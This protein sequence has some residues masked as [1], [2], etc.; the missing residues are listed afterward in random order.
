[1]SIQHLYDGAQLLC[2]TLAKLDEQAHLSIQMGD[3]M[4]DYA[5]IVAAERPQPLGR[6][7]DPTQQD[8]SGGRAFWIIA[9][10]PDGELVHTQA[11]RRLDLGTQNLADFLR[12]NFQSFPPPGLPI[13]FENSACNAGPGA[14]RISGRV[15][16]HG[17]I[18]VKDSPDYRGNGLID[19]L[20]RLGLLS[21]SMHWQPDFIFGFMG[22]GNARRG[23]CERFGYMHSDPY[24][25]TWSIQNRNQ[26]FIANL[27]WMTNEDIH[28]TTHVPLDEVSAA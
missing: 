11:L 10:N 23:L 28:F 17:E 22:R 26:R 27:T 20:A 1:M 25:L 14:R 6:P 21:A 18:W 5:D 8:L 3:V 15:A 13:D 19:Y 2:R 16:Y 4:E 7:F 12:N 24:A 9:R